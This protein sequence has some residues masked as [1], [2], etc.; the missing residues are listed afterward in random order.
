MILPAVRWPAGPRVARRPCRARRI[1]VTHSIGLHRLR[2]RR[3]G[4]GARSRRKASGRSRSRSASIPSAMSRWCG[5]IRDRGRRGVATL[6]RRQRRLQDARRGH[7][8][9]FRQMEP[10][11]LKYVEQPVMGI[12]RLAEVARAIDT[13]VMADE[14]GLERARCDPDH[15][16]PRRADRLD[17]HHEAGR[18]LSAR[19]RSRPSAAPPASSA[20]STARS[21]PASAI[22]PISI[23]PRRR[24]PSSLSCVVPVS[25]PAE[26]QHGQ[27][28]GIY[29]KDDLIS[30]ADAICRRRHRIAGRARHGHRSSTK[31][32]SHSTRV[33][34]S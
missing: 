10:Y 3:G 28:G 26:A 5:A 7:S 24:R 17:L 30:R 8:R 19:W 25:T 22:S 15:R 4:S 1:P 20:T 21:R 14:V 23:S 16:T 6:R 2:G 31:R 29:Y 32:K 12:E 13:P 9:R 33:N 27:I 34:R 18:A 11:D